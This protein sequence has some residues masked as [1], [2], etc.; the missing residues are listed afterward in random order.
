M[1]LKLI[2]LLG[3]TFILTSC[4]KQREQVLQIQNFTARV[5]S[6]QNTSFSNASRPQVV[7]LQPGQHMV[8]LTQVADKPSEQPTCPTQLDPSF[9]FTVYD[10]RDTL[11]VDSLLQVMTVESNTVKQG[12]RGTERFTCTLIYE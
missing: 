3:I 1:R 9:R 4:A 7:E 10:G 6:V 5:I 12:I 8:L 11:L 2:M